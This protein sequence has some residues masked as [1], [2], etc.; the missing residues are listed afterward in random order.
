[1]PSTAG[2]Y[3]ETKDPDACMGNIS[4]TM[5]ERMRHLL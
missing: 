2:H 4:P 5:R 3:N 1:V